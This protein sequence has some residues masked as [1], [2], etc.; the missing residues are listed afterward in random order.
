M[1]GKDQLGLVNYGHEEWLEEDIR[2]LNYFRVIKQK[3]KKKKNPR[4]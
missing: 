1:S 3:K 2:S 4:L